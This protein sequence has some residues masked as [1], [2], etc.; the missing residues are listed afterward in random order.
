MDVPYWLSQHRR[1]GSSLVWQDETGTRAFP[2][3][4]A[5][6]QQDLLDAVNAYLDGGAPQVPLD[7]PNVLT[8]TDAD[9][10]DTAFAPADA[11]GLY[12]GYAAHSIAME[13]TQQFAWRLDDYSGDELARLLSGRHMFHFGGGV[14]RLDD[15]VEWAV[16]APP[17]QVREFLT[18]AGIVADDRLLTL[19]RLL[20]WCRDHMLH[21][22]GPT[23]AATMQA[24]WQYRGYPPVSRVIAGTVDA[25][26]PTRGKQHW[27][28]GCWGTS[29]FLRSVLRAVNIPATSAYRIGHRLPAFTADRRYL[30]HGDDPYNQN[31]IAVKEIAGSDLLITKSAFDARFAGTVNVDDIGYRV[32]QLALGEVWRSTWTPGWTSFVPLHP[33]WDV[34]HYLAY[35]SGNGAVAIDRL[36]IGGEGVDTVW[37][38]TWTTGWS[39]FVP[40]ST[41]AGQHYLAYKVKTGRVVIDRVRPNAQGVDTVWESAWTTGW[42]SFVP[43]QV[44][45]VTHYLAYKRGSGVVTVDRIRPDASGVDTLWTGKWT[46]GWTSFALVPTDPQLLFSVKAVVPDTPLAWMLALLPFGPKLHS[47][48][49]VD[50][51]RPDTTDIPLWTGNGMPGWSSVMAFDDATGPGNVLLYNVSTGALRVVEVSKTGLSTVYADQWTKGWTSIVALRA[52]GRPW[53]L[54]YKLNQGTVTINH[55]CG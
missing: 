7:P 15:Q 16:P 3:W 55:L 6:R 26:N 53:Y 44:G 50:E 49:A 46:T 27:T 24:V 4:P 8:L 17:H 25:N 43:F 13:I 9:L 52:Y 32:W 11:W 30:S 20:D 54:T 23:V 42:T 35:K 47:Y 51:I 33:R 38:D 45:G 37:Q 2:S 41:E 22:F 21:F 39:S 1:I 12:R 34:A 5:Q 10:P 19:S 31:T 48:L 40:F 28:S 36:H 14:Y 29:G 18:G